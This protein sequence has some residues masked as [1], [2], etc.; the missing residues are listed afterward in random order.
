MG[1]SLDLAH[2]HLL[3]LSKL[4]GRTGGLGDTWALNENFSA[5]TRLSP[6]RLLHALGQGFSAAA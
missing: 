5:T 1:Q 2:A 6:L 3:H 4:L